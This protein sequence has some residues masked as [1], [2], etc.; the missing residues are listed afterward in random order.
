MMTKSLLYRFGGALCLLIAAGAAWFGVYQPLQSAAGKAEVVTSMPKVMVL[1]S[2]ATVFGVFFIFTGDRY[3]Y[4]NVEKQTLTPVGWV[5]FGIT[6]VAA[7][8]GYFWMDA[9]LR[10]M[11]Y[12]P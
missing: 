7:F 1:I 6:A 10:G 9:M 4:R 2:V 3:P 5:L 11:G 8:G 12:R